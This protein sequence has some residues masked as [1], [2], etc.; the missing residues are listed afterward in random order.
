MNQQ[1]QLDAFGE[2]LEL[3]AVASSFDRLDSDHWDAVETAV[4]SHRTTLGRTR[5]RDLGTGQSTVGPF[6]LDLC[7]RT[8]SYRSSTRPVL[9]R[10]S[11][12]DWPTRSWPTSRATASTPTGG[13]SALQAIRGSMRLCC[14]RESVSLCRQ[15]ILGRWRPSI[16]WRPSYCGTIMSTASPTTRGRSARPKGAFLLCG[17]LLALALD[18]QGKHLSARALFERNR[19]ACGTPGSIGRRVRHHSATTPRQHSPS[20]RPCTAARM[21]RHAFSWRSAASSGVVLL[22]NTWIRELNGG[23]A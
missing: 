7:R 16:P 11:G 5:C 21:Q 13:G 14:S 20:I 8:P 12:V 9:S 3:M 18:Q 17:F 15:M 2:A 19:S 10:A 4:S 23:S 22:P 6:S 1:F